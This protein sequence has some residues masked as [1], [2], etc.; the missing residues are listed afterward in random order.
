MNLLSILPTPADCHGCRGSRP[1]ATTETV[2]DPACRLEVLTLTD[3]NR[4]RT[5]SP[6]LSVTPTPLSI[7]SSPSEHES[8]P[9]ERE[10]IPSE[11]ESIPSE[12]EYIPSAGDSAGGADADGLRARYRRGRAGV[13]EATPPRHAPPPG[14]LK[15]SAAAQCSAV[16]QGA[17]Y[18]TAH[19][20]YIKK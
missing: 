16:Q 13:S 2:G 4:V 3:I 11:R 7:E 14:E 8:T 1:S 20:K 12:R 10:S 15:Y 9:S 6:L 5:S 19:S 17:V 18:R